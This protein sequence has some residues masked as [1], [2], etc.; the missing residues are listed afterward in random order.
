MN[1]DATVHEPAR[2][3]IMSILS[4]VAS[5]DFALLLTTTGLTR[6]NLSS[7]MAR[8]ERAGYVEI[9]K[10]FLGKVPHT[11]YRLTP[12]GAEALKRYWEEI[13]AIRAQYAPEV[14]SQQ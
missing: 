11:D 6:G 3:L 7:H 8:L 1:P 4:G 10:S 13:D 14:S 5:A 12:E 2:L 9:T